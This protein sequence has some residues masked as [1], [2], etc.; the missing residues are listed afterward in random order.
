MYVKSYFYIGC[1]CDGIEYLI[2]NV[3]WLDHSRYRLG[4]TG[5][6][7]GL[8][9]LGCMVHIGMLLLLIYQSPKKAG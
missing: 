9:A 8:L 2:R 6:V 3:S 7:I 1:G 5:L 4:D